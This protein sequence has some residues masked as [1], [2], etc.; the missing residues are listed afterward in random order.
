VITRAGA[1][2]VTGLAFGG[3]ASRPEA[4]EKAEAI[5]QRLAARGV[6]LTEPAAAVATYA[7]YRIVGDMVYLAGQGP[8]AGQGAKVL[9]KLGR[10]LTVEEGAYAARLTAIA[11]LAQAKAACGGDLGRI[12]QWVRLT[13]YVNSSD[14]FTEQPKVI[15][16]ASDLLVEIFGEKGMHARAAVSVNSLPFDIAVEIEASFQIRL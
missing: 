5:E 8:A 12:V 9:G 10:D 4:G 13:G 3:L 1:A 2:G 16:G 15:N 6:V 7:P 14:D 11:I